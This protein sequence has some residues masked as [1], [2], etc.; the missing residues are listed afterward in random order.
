MRPS[1]FQVACIADDNAKAAMDVDLCGTLKVGGAPPM[2][3]Y[4]CRTAN[5]S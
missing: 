5:L 1:R 2:V 3:A 4:S